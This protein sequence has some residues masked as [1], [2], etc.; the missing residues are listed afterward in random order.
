MRILYVAPNVIIPGS[1][2]GSTHVTEVVRALREEHDVLLL[3]RRGSTGPG[4]VGI[5]G[6]LA[7]GPLRYGL[8]CLHFPFAYSHARR[9]RPH[10]VYERFSAFGLGVMLGRALGAP[11]VSM[12][13]DGS[14][15]LIT[16]EG[17]DRLITTAPHLVPRRYRHKVE[18]V[19]WGANTE[20]FTP[21]VDGRP[22]RSELGI[23][24]DELVIGYTGGF[25]HW[26]GLETLV[27]AAS[28]LAHA[29]GASRFRFLLVGDGERRRE[30]ERYIARARLEHRFL[31]PG[32]VPYEAV[33]RFVAACD[34]CVA[35][36][37]PGRHRD[38]RRRGMYFDPLKVFEYLAAGKPTITLDSE[39]IR[40][41]FRH[42]EHV[43][44]VPPGDANRLA[45]AL[46]V[47]A[48]DRDLRE[49]LG[50]AGRAIVSERYTWRA[51]GRQLGRI[52]SELTARGSAA[53]GGRQ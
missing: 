40:R 24:D 45:E 13:L 1:H 8:P 26:H 3:A 52:F 36:Y 16:F 20:L 14:A 9:F 31:L 15:T 53:S 18:E 2:G 25:Y 33:P 7:P 49:R 48:D 11:V 51:H 12:V 35:A 6:K 50:R 37:D 29:P 42:G 38:L 10:A 34:V 27:D 21:E 44:L 4:V 46:L 5:G 19:S 28:K 17:A 41:M 30:V 22:T 39:N 43:M 23:V 47:L 32:R